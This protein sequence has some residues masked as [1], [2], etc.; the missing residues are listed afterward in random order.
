MDNNLDFLSIPPSTRRAPLP[1]GL[2]LHW[3]ASTEY[4]RLPSSGDERGA[5]S[6]AASDGEFDRDESLAALS[7]ARAAITAK[8]PARANN[9]VLTV[10]TTDQVRHWYRLA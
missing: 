4:T 6:A 8:P 10:R 1:R 7:A 3:Q 5:S 2:N 9:A